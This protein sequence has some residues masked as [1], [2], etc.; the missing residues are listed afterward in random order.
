MRAEVG[1]YIELVSM[2]DDPDPIAPGTKGT[3]TFINEVQEFTQYEVDWDNG[4]A[5][6]LS[7]PPDQFRLAT[8][9][10]TRKA[11]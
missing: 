5:L 1:D 8:R 3:V 9:E 11:R 2:R 7:V 10:I 4:R 6:M